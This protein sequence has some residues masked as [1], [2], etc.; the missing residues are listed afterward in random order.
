MR[1]EIHCNVKGKWVL[2]SLFDDK[3]LALDE[4]N[5]L[6]TR[7]RARLGLKVIEDADDARTPPRTIFF[8]SAAA[9]EKMDAAKKHKVVVKEV[10]AAREERKVKKEAVR[11]AAVV[12]AA[13]KKT[14]TAMIAV[15]LGLILV[16]GIVALQTLRMTLLQ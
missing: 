11:Q 15:R 4:A 13:P 7:G 16:G 8:Y 9:V 6:V 14:S 12:A 10:E 1:Y 5:G 3:T 2:D